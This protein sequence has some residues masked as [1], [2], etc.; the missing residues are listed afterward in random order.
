MKKIILASASPRRRELLGITGYDFEVIPSGCSEDTS[1]SEPEEYVSVLSKRKCLDVAGR[2]NCDV[3]VVGADTVV[4]L[5]G[6]IIGKPSGPDDAFSMLR[7]L[8]GR[9]H[10]VYTGICVF[11]PS[12]GRIETSCERTEVRFFELSD[13]EIR[14]YI[15]TGEPMDK[16]G[17]YGIQYKGS[18]LVE[19]INGDYFNVVGLPLAKLWRILD[20]FENGTSLKD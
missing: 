7:H 6:H 2:V 17:A 4:V 18:Y 9:T 3:I 1:S 16:A 12:S 11:E 13:E 15:A 20:S 5:D 8:S 19:S 14:A 10:S